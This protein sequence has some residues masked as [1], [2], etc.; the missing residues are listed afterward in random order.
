MIALTALALAG[1]VTLAFTVTLR[2]MIRE[3]ARE[4]QLLIN[5]LLHATG[6]TWQPAPADERTAPD[7]EPR[8]A[9]TATPEQFN[10]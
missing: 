10:T 2:R 6:K 9:Y 5:Q 8:T 7:V 4:R 3:H 1:I